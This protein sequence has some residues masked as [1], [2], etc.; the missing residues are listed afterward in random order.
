M[1][2]DQSATTA[3]LV[4]SLDG[5]NYRFDDLTELLA[6]L[7]DGGD[8]GEGKT[9]HAGTAIRHK[10]SEFF[11]VDSLVD[12]MQNRAYDEAGEWAEDFPDISKEQSKELGDLIGAWLD[13][14][15][16]VNFWT[17]GDAKEIQ[18]TAAM[19]AE[20]KRREA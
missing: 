1:N 16:N 7:E 17:V 12:D 15:V 3:E 10:A 14:N 8:L 5:E 19:I 18:I 11:Y 4:Y 13:K 6:E 9:I 20:F 2:T